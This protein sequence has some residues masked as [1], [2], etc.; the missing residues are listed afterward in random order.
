M[1]R[2]R[3]HRPMTRE[4][5]RAW[6]ERRQRQKEREEEKAAQARRTA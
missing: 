3:P 6:Q 2:A 1:A 5:A 4:E